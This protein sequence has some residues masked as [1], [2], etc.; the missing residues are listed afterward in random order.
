MCLGYGHVRQL[1]L[2]KAYITASFGHVRSPALPLFLA[3]DG[4]D[5]G[6]GA[7]IFQR[8]SAGQE[9]VIEYA[10]NT[11]TLLSNSERSI[12]NY[13]WRPEVPLLSSWV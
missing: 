11:L 3:C 7:C 12:I 2:S 6:L 4:S 8:N 10:S 9:Q 1:L 5:K 13:L